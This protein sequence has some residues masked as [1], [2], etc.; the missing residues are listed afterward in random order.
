MTEFSRSHP[1]PVPSA[2][3]RTAVAEGLRSLRARAPHGG[4]GMTTHRPGAFRSRPHAGPALCAAD[5][6]ARRT[7]AARGHVVRPAAATALPVPEVHA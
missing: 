1:G 3:S 2:E 7:A 6:P 4:G 5:G